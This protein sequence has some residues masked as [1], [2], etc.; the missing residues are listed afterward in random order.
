MD[1]PVVEG[2]AV[3]SAEDVGVANCAAGAGTVGV[4]VLEVRTTN[5]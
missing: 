5:K 4:P 2:V 1:G 3:E